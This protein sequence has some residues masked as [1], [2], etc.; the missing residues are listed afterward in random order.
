MAFQ[1]TEYFKEKAKESCK[2]EAKNCEL[3]HRHGYDVASSSGLIGMQIQG[4]MAIFAELEANNEPG[5]LRTR[6][7]RLEKSGTFRKIRIR[8]RF[9]IRLILGLPE[10]LLVL[11]RPLTKDWAFNI[12]KCGSEILLFNKRH[13]ALHM[14]RMREHIHRSYLHCLV[15]AIFE[16]PQVSGQCRWITRHIHHT[17]RLHSQN[18]L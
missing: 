4:A 16:H 7:K 3:R 9:F 18:R 1:E 12:G 11:Q 2:I 17:L 10:K 6:K 13:T 5:R 14:H 8:Y 15:S